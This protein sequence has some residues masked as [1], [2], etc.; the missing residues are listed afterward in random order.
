V[1]ADATY[2]TTIGNLKLNPQTGFADWNQD[3]P[4][5]IDF[6][7]LLSGQAI[8]PT[9]NENFGQVND[10]YI[11]DQV[12]KLGP[13]PTSELSKYRA[14]WE[15][16]DEYTAKKAYVAVFGYQTFPKFTS[17]RINYGAAI[18]HP[19]YGWDW[20]SFALK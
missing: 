3:F 4:N 17:A 12:N 20:S 2:F 15:A 18:F 14:Q 6:Y 1:I 13:V 19:V 7:L 5:P 16:V 9:N 10:P 8:L 11:N